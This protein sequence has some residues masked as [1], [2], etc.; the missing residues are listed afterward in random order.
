MPGRASEILGLLAVLWS[1][2]SGADV[3]LRRIAAPVVSSFALALRVC[4]AICA[5]WQRRG[6]PPA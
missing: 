6:L 4:P 1:D 2:A 5:V 3:T